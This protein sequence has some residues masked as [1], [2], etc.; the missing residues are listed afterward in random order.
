MPH[1]NIAIFIPHAGCSH[2]CSFCN[3]RSISGTQRPPSPVEVRQVCA[4]AFGQIKNRGDTQIAF[5]GGSFT[6]VDPAYRRELLLSVQDFIGPGKFQGIR[7]STRPDCIDADIL[8]ELKL[9]GVTA[10]ELGAQS[11]C[12]EVLRQNRRGH[13][14][15]DVRR[16]SALIREAGFELGLQMMVGLY[17]SSVE[18]DLRTADEIVRL[19]PRTVRVYPT[20]ILEDTNLARLYQGG[21]Y[22]PM[23]LEDAVQICARMLR[24]FEENGIAVIRLG[25]HASEEME[26]RML[27]GVYHPA[28][29]ELCE[30]RIFREELNFALAGRT[31]RFLAEVP[32]GAVSKAV[33]HKRANR[34]FFAGKG[35]YLRFRPAGDLGGYT[36]RLTEEV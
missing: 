36:I 26:G 21:V 7:V 35:V 27:G 1:N 32:P 22:T 31:G 24:L 5:F 33:G 25:L 15:Q 23:E 3:Q 13:T 29:R 16:A 11:L 20:V 9:F 28:F 6:A 34:D 18:E 30:A 4:Q 17:G 8:A 12:D 19:H 14:A 10:V 2:Q